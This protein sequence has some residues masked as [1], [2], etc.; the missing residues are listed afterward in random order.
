MTTP[1]KF[2]ELT[3]WDDD[4]GGLR[5]GGA[6]WAAPG[7][8]AFIDRADPYWGHVLDK[9]RTAYGDPNMG[10][11]TDNV[12]QER[13]LVFGDGTPVPSDGA[14]A[15]RD[16]A[17][18]QT[19]LLNNDGTV[20]PLGAN[21]VAG[22]P[23]TPAGFRRNDNGTFAP[24]DPSGHQIAPL[25]DAPPSTSHG[26]YDANG[27]LTPKNARGD[28]YTDDPTTGKRTYFD[29]NGSPITAAQFGADKPAPAH[30]PIEPT[31]EQQSGRAADAVRQLH[32]ELANRYSQ[33]SDAEAKRLQTLP[34][35]GNAPPSQP[36]AVESR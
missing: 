33:I 5:A 9:A 24:V 30:P 18:H 28:Y 21:D 35:A 15:Y 26:Y 25:T 32:D 14:L 3:A 6:G 17:R 29:K 7:S 1:R 34:S 2:D 27:L 22:Q 36:A 13:R 16:A 8:N 23:I 31:D 10:F 11:N 4:P 20:S 12:G 19:Y